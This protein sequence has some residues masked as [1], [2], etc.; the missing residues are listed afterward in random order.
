MSIYHLPES[1]LYSIGDYIC[2]YYQHSHSS[3][4]YTNVKEYINWSCTHKKLYSKQKIVHLYNVFR[5]IQKYNKQQKEYDDEFTYQSP[6]KKDTKKWMNPILLDIFFSGVCLPFASSTFPLYNAERDLDAT[7]IIQMYPKFVHSDFG[8]LRCR[9]KVSPLYVACL[10]SNVPIQTIECLLKAGANQ[11]FIDVNGNQ[12][13]L[14]DDIQDTI[15]L[16]RYQQCIRLF[17]QYQI[18]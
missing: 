17:K 5:F 15:S 18:L 9:Y 13:H 3:V 2:I 6:L 4:Y 7:Y 11:C 10:N 14:L 1:I 16:E 8:M 12:T